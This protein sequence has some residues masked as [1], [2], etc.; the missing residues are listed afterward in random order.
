MGIDCV[1]IVGLGYVGLPLACICAKNGFKVRGLDL[2]KEKVALINAGKSPIKDGF[3]EASLG[4]FKGKI[5]AFE[6]PA[7]AVTRTE[8]V[9]Q[10][11]E[12][13]GKR[14]EEAVQQ[15]NA[16]VR[17]MKTRVRTLVRYYKSRE[18]DHETTAK[19]IAKLQE[20]VNF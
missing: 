9:K 8:E 2:N 4:R 7:E 13:A 5:K 16:A 6:N 1:S 14:A 10:A 19:L 11:A 15:A 3:V 18:K 20:A 17:D 12:A